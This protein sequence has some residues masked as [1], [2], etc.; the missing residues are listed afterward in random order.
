MKERVPERVFQFADFL[1]QAGFQEHAKIA[2]N[3]RLGSH[4]VHICQTLG[5]FGGKRGDF[6]IRE[7]FGKRNLERRNRQNAVQGIAPPLPLPGHARVL[8]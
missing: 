5:V 2:K 7:N 1:C 3:F 4:D 8:I 6:S